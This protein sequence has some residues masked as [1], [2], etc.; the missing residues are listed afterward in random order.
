[1]TRITEKQRITI[2]RLFAGGATMHNLA[3]SYGVTVDRIEAII[4][5]AMK[6]ADVQP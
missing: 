2:V 5:D 6:Q 1:M 4:R 3:E